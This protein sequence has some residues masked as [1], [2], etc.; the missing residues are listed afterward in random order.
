MLKLIIQSRNQNTIKS[1][2]IAQIKKDDNFILVRA[3]VQALIDFLSGHMD[4]LDQVI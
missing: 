2:F 1:L 4:Y 3:T